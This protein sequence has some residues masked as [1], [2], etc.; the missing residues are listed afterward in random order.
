MRNTERVWMDVFKDFNTRVEMFNLFE[1][2][3]IIKNK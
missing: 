2:V 3:D 1:K